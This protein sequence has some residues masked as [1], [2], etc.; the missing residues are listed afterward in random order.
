MTDVHGCRYLSFK[1]IIYEYKTTLHYNTRPLS[2]V[3]LFAS[4]QGGRENHG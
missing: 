4:H 1:F 3:I 2:G